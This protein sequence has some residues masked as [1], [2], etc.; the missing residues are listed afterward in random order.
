MPVDFREAQREALP[1]LLGFRYGRVVLG[2]EAFVLRHRIQA[3]LWITAVEV[4]VFRT[5][6]NVLV[7]LSWGAAPTAAGA[8]S[9]CHSKPPHEVPESYDRPTTSA[10]LGN[11]S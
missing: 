6:N 11:A 5:V 10:T 1:A 4:Q 9:C 2:A 3:T 7:D 8:P